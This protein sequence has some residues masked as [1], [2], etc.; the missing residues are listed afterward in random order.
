M[1]LGRSDNDNDPDLE[2]SSYSSWFTQ[3]DITVA[4]RIFRLT[5]V[6]PRWSVEVVADDGAST[7]WGNLFE[8]G[9]DAYLAFCQF[10]DRE[11]IGAF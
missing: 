3:E 11:G 5:K 4:L 6:D 8:T 9:S 2:M 7:T 10:V 1:G